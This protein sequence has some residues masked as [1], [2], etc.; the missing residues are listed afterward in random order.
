MRY[1]RSREFAGILLLF[2]ITWYISVFYYQLMLLRGDSM[3]PTYHSGQFLILDKH[4]R[5]YNYGDVIAFKKDGINGYLVK[6]IF[7]VP[8]DWVCIRDGIIYINGQPQYE[9]MQRIDFA[10]IA[11]EQI[12]LGEDDYFVLGDNFDRSRDSRYV[13]IGPVSRDE[14]KGKV[15]R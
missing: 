6:R 10:G 12:L 8:G 11:G 2:L 14:I 9:E 3:E 13:E 7:A 1:I 15:I 4:S 5:D